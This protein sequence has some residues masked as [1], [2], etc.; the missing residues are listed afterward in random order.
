MTHI[1]LL[2]DFVV[3]LGAATIV[4][5]ISHRLRIPA[6][7]GFLLTGLLIG[8]SGLALISDVHQV[9]ILAE[10]GVVALLFVIGLEFSL[11]RLK[12]I[13][14]P[15]LIGGSLQAIFTIS[16]TVAISLYL[17]FELAESVFFGFLIT[18]SST[19]LVLKVFGDREELDAP[20]GKLIIGILLFQDFLVVPM[21]ILTPVLAGAVEASPASVAIRFGGGVLIMAVVFVV[22]RFL[23]PHV[24]RL[25]VKTGIREIL[26][27]GALFI[28]LGMAM[29]TESLEFS[30][31]LGAFIA[32][33]II[34]ESEY[35]HQVVADI[36]PFRDVFNSI[37]FISIG[38]LLN[39]DFVVANV[40]AVLLFAAGLMLLKLIIITLIVLVMKFPIRTALMTG[41]GL[42][43]IGEFS[44][45][46]A[47]VGIGV[48]LLSG[49]LYQSFLAG[50][51][52]TMMVTPFFVQLS[53]QIT[54]LADRVLP[55]RDKA[56][57]APVPKTLQHHVV[58]VGYGVA[59]ENI[60][61]VLK[62]TGIP[63]IIAELSGESVD[64][65]K[66]RGEPIVFGD[67]T[68]RDILAYVRIRDARVI[69]IAISDPD[70]T[71]RIVRF[72]RQ[73]NPEI[74]IIVRTSFVH[75]IAELLN[76]GANTVLAEE[77][78]TS[79]EIFT[80]VLER[81][82][83]PRNVIQAQRRVLRAEGYEML[84]GEEREV[85]QAVLDILA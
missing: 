85:S 80:R 33:I 53:P 35:S 6:L 58:L 55:F 7:V 65:A 25:I 71:R 84:R 72:A 8:P 16:I 36:L 44:F 10:F 41:V 14:R 27:V 79:I 54:R 49:D 61:M 67:A 26:V 46:L 38:M 68:R 20:H 48:D 9:E 30:L 52:L 39:L 42:A 62:K 34:S 23:M 56:E 50:A 11:E 2:Y 12:Q 77:F 74:N 81:Y 1:P 24:L 73:L 83:V 45:I 60:A 5:L 31:A 28:C 3:I 32:G 76:L 4:I 57:A 18:L 17:G 51:I 37:F 69:V 29:L 59:G 15:F 75:E 82:H 40:A 47:N 66:K 19:A 64:R 70:A 43:Q 63:Y 21:I 22:A 78:E 13:R